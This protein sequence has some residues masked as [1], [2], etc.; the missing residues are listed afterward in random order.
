MHKQVRIGCH[1]A[2]GRPHQVRFKRDANGKINPR[3]GSLGSASNQ[4][5]IKYSEEARFVFGVAMKSANGTDTGYCLPIFDY[6]CE[7]MVTHKDWMDTPLL[8]H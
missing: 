4:L 2:T 8:L 7:N 1:G 5:N 6:R 3:T